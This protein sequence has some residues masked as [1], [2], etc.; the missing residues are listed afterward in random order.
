MG[1]V[2]TINPSVD[3]TVRVFDEFYEF[4]VDVDA[5]EYDVVNSFF[6]SAFG[7]KDAA[8]NFTATLFRIADQTQTPVLTLL[9]EIEDMD[10]VQLTATLAYYLNNIRSPATLLGI[11]AVTTPNYYAARNVRN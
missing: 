8:A 6:E 3:L 10:K 11:N 5:N 4:A 2:N 7:T 9:A 1:S